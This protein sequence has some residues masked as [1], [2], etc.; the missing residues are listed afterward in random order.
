M[1]MLYSWYYITQTNKVQPTAAVLAMPNDPTACL[2]F[3]TFDALHR[4]KKTKLLAVP[5]IGST[6]SS[7]PYEFIVH[8]GQYNVYAMDYKDA[9]ATLFE[10]EPKIKPKDIMFRDLKTCKVPKTKHY[11]NFSKI[12][13][14]FQY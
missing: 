11:I 4:K 8:D 5:F 2:L 13:L 1:A 3:V 14:T 6:I 7:Q 12:L 9:W 10:N